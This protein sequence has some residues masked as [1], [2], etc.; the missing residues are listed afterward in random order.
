M[1]LA[2]INPDTS[3]GGDPVLSQP[4]DS[5][6]A[7]GLKG[8]NQLRIEDAELLRADRHADIAV[9]EDH[10]R[11]LLGLVLGSSHKLE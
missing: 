6:I 9:K 10:D 2:V 5:L 3:T 7:V 4:H 11:G 1:S 8:E